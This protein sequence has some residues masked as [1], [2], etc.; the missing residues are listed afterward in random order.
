M[1]RK[2]GNV[3]KKLSNILKP[4]TVFPIFTLFVAVVILVFASV[5]GTYFELSWEGWKPNIT[6]KPKGKSEL[7]ELGRGV[8]QPT[9]SE[10]PYDPSSEI[11]EEYRDD[12]RKRDEIIAEYDHFLVSFV[13]VWIR[14]N[15]GNATI[16]TR[17]PANNE[18]RRELY[19]CVQRIFRHFGIYD[20]EINGDQNDTFRALI[21]FQKARGLK[22]IDG[23]IGRESWNAMVDTYEELRG[24]PK[25]LDVFRFK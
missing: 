6:V 3:R 2:K 16:N 4:K 21:D 10:H 19:R 11:L 7:T 14:L 24:K 18:K 15:G 20:G 25:S 8:S 17:S 13:M 22:K 23:I 5:M 9:V 12:I 1:R